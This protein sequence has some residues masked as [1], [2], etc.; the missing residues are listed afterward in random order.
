MARES[1][2]WPKPNNKLAT[3]KGRQKTSL[4]SLIER[5]VAM[6]KSGEKKSDIY[7]QLHLDRHPKEI[8]EAVTKACEP[9][10]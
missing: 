2:D 9:Y 3:H 8:R 6:A 4:A 10:L 1:D 7:R 5:A